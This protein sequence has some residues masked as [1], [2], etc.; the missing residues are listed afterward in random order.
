MDNKRRV[1]LRLPF[2]PLSWSILCAILAKKKI[3]REWVLWFCQFMRAFL[4]C[5]AGIPRICQY[6]KRCWRHGLCHR[7]SPQRAS[8]RFPV[9]G[10]T[11]QNKRET[12]H[13][14]KRSDC[15]KGTSPYYIEQKLPFSGWMLFINIFDYLQNTNDPDTPNNTNFFSSVKHFHLLKQYTL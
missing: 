12:P 1:A 6:R 7:K 14:K 9:V 10:W 8:S 2:V 4:W 11:F 15:G 5:L 13:H 3:N